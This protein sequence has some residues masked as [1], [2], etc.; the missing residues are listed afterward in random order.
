M[1]YIPRLFVV[2]FSHALQ[3]HLH[4]MFVHVVD[5]CVHFVMIH[6]MIGIIN[7]SHLDLHALYTLQTV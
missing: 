7:N 2:L 4:I 3:M 1:A 5:Q 6:T